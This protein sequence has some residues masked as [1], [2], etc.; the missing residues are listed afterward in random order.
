MS[1]LSYLAVK[2]L[3]YWISNISYEADG[4]RLRGR[5]A[6]RN[7]W[8]PT[9]HHKNLVK[10]TRPFHNQP[11]SA[12]IRAKFALNFAATL[13]VILT[14]RN[15]TEFPGE[16]SSSRM[17]SCHPAHVCFK[18]MS[19]SSRLLG[20]IPKEQGSFLKGVEYVG[21]KMEWILCI[22]LG[23]SLGLGLRDQVLLHSVFR[24]MNSCLALALWRFY[25]K[26]AKFLD[27][28]RGVSCCYFLLCPMNHLFASLFRQMGLKD[29]EFCIAG[30][31]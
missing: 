12:H 24:I 4:R 5:G 29:T 8:L 22:S 28:Y 20:L 6:C 9:D 16:S 25:M 10:K 7:S 26:L 30:I 13:N 21:D 3:L 23:R 15:S 19:P 2:Q 11:Y 31:T 14:K 1:K 17:L 18:I 27:L